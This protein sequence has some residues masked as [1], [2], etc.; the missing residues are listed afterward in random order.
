MGTSELAKNITDL[1]Q[2]LKKS[3]RRIK[4]TL[5][6]ESKTKTASVH[7]GDKTEIE[8]EH[9]QSHI[10]SRHMWQSSSKD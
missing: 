7:Y 2:H 10:Q 3:D 4:I 5:A 1:V 8:S 9:L 6:Y